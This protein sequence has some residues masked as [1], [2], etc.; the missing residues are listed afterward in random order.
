MP[1]VP[2]S[3]VPS[4]RKKRKFLL[5]LQSFCTSCRTADA[6]RA[7]L[8]KMISQ[9]TTQ[10]NV[11]LPP[12]HT[13]P[14]SINSLPKSACFGLLIFFFF[15]CILS[16]VY[17]NQLQEHCNS[18]MFRAEIPWRGNFLCATFIQVFVGWTP[19]VSLNI[20]RPYPLRLLHTFR[21][22]A[23]RAGAYS[24]GYIHYYV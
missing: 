13:F 5:T 4:P 8:Q 10:K 23:T 6:F 22:T 2:S 14:P 17:L 3:L 11:S 16:R 1:Q 18:S 7:K 20:V 9:P 19:R 15:F 21:R 12:S 24:V